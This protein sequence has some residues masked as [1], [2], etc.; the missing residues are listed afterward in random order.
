MDVRKSEKRNRSKWNSEIRNDKKNA[1]RV[2]L[3]A[4]KSVSA[5][6]GSG[7][8]LLLHKFICTLQQLCSDDHLHT[9][10]LNLS[11]V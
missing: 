4:G 6:D 10:I 11:Y 7:V 9:P 1:M 2:F 5:D 8:N 3:L